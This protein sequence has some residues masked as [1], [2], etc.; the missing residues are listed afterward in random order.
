MSTTT[1]INI[2]GTKFNRLSL[3]NISPVDP[4]KVEHTPEPKGTQPSQAMKKYQNQYSEFAFSKISPPLYGN[5]DSIARH[6]GLPA[7]KPDFIADYHF[8][9]LMRSIDDILTPLYTGYIGGTTTTPG[10]T[11]E[12][13]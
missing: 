2:P 12:N 5:K 3:T 6:T 13:S 9:G 1:P 7:N 8:I 4:L 10:E 11:N